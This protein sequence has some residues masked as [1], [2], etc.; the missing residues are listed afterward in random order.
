MQTRFDLKT[1]QVR[2]RLFRKLFQR[3]EALKQMQST[4]VHFVFVVNEHGGVEGNPLHA[5]IPLL[6][7]V[8][9]G[10]I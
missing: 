7:A 5:L 2:R 9:Y 1:F 3:G 10:L 8:G 6:S 4:R